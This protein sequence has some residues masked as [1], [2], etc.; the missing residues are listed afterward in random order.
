[1]SSGRG[2]GIANEGKKKRTDDT[3]SETVLKKPKQETSTVSSSVKVLY[4]EEKGKGQKK[5][6]FI[7]VN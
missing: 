3:S 2:Q 5:S 4:T 7:F 1:M 6:C